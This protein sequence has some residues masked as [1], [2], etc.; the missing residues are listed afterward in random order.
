V[1]FNSVSYLLF[2]PIVV[3]AFWRLP[4]RFRAPLLL[5]AS[6]YF[7]MSWFPLY[8]LMLGGLTLLNYGLGMAIAAIKPARP[9]LAKRVL[10]TGIVL[11]LFTLAYFKYTDFLIESINKILAISPLETAAQLPMAHILLPLGISFFV[12]EFIHYLTDI[13]KGSRPIKDIVHFSL[14]AA[15]FPSQIAGPIKRYQDFVKQLEIPRRF[16]AARL[17]AGLALIMQG[18]FKKIA[19]ADNLSSLVSI[20]FANAAS[21]GAAEAW[22]TA[23]AFTVQIYCDFSGYTDMGRGSALMMGFDLPPNF[24]W[25]YIASDLSDF[26]KRWH[27]SLS[28]WLR[29]YLYI[30]MGGSRCS[31][32]RKQFNLVTTMVLGGLWHGAAWHFVIWG[33]F[34]GLGLVV[35]HMYARFVKGEG[36]VSV[37]LQK[38]HATKYGA[39]TSV[40]LTLLF[41]VVG[42]V[43]FRASTMGEAGALLQSAITPVPSHYLE[44]A[45]LK[46]PGF[47]ALGVYCVGFCLLRLWERMPRLR[48][49][50]PARLVGYVAVFLA[51]VGFSPLGEAPFIYFQF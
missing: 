16:D 35:S 24:N 10:I 1:L 25:P 51:A 38:W 31:D 40:G 22:G 15:F 32:S 45:Y 6:A 34:H 2:L 46:Y 5:V 8:G 41:V 43:F 12:F 44:D 19:I 23:I 7:Y 13:Y 30:P 48:P 20:G 33:A 47:A 42:W 18:L 4:H 27:I 9:L 36:A 28:S 26:W 29:D 49:L 3:L 39:A 17:E 14:F 21:L 50:L 37:A 11:N